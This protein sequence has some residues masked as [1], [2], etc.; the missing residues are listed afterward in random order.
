MRRRP[1]VF[2]FFFGGGRREGERPSARVFF[3]QPGG[4]HVPLGPCSSDPLAATIRSLNGSRQAWRQRAR[5]RARVH[6][7]QRAPSCRP[8]FAAAPIT[9]PLCCVSPCLGRVSHPSTRS[10]T[11]P[12]CLRSHTP[13]I[14]RAPSTCAAHLLLLISFSSFFFLLPA[15]VGIA[16]V[17]GGPVAQRVEGGLNTRRGRR[18][19][20]VRALHQ[21]HGQPVPG[22]D[23]GGRGKGARLAAG[24]QAR[25]RGRRLGARVAGLGGRGR[26]GGGVSGWRRGGGSP[27][28]PGGGGRPGPGERTGCGRAR[29]GSSAH[30]LD[31]K[32]QGGGR[33]RGLYVCGAGGV[34]VC[35]GGK[36]HTQARVECVAGRRSEWSGREFFFFFFHHHQYARRPRRR[37]PT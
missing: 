24:Q 14:G 28:G 25:V 10:Q 5:A 30:F 23:Q 9:T 16:Q 11:W 12:P 13:S 36:G 15:L 19:T 33:A 17:P 34:S 32:E 7:R 26:A 22:G 18:R 35:R 20:R 21:F 29:G 4:V 3:C 8:T 1:H 31:A 27:D 6:V 37:P 2:F